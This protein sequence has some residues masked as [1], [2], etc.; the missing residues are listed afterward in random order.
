VEKQHVQVTV[1][2]KHSNSA[3]WIDN[4]PQNSFSCGT[5]LK[6]LQKMSRKFVHAPICPTFSI[7]RRVFFRCFRFCVCIHVLH[8]E[9]F[10]KAKVQLTCI[11][12][13]RINCCIRWSNLFSN[14]YIRPTM[15][16]INL[17]IL[18]D[19]SSMLRAICAI[20]SGAMP[21]ITGSLVS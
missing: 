12:E 21:A 20:P 1:K 4:S 18:V 2:L 6:A 3:I 17:Y 15:R 5:N 7:I 9:K 14:I 10:V 19:L 13:G 8:R 11:N 16:E